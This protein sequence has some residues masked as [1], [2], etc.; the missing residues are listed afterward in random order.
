MFLFVKIV[1]PKLGLILK[2]FSREK[3]D[4][5]SVRKRLLEL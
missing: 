2:K 5:G 1:N 3:L 4:V